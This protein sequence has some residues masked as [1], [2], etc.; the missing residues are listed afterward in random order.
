[1]VEIIVLFFIII[2]LM[3]VAIAAI[4]IIILICKVKCLNIVLT[5]NI[6]LIKNLVTDLLI[7]LKAYN[8]CT[9]KNKSFKR[10]I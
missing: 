9:F 4:N 7:Q 3:F 5:K 1:M 8:D 10:D 6:S 2:L